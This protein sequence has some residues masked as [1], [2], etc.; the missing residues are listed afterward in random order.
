MLTLDEDCVSVVLPPSAAES[1]EMTR[2]LE[3]LRFPNKRLR[4]DEDD[5][6]CTEE[7]NALLAHARDLRWSKNIFQ[8]M[9]KTCCYLTGAL[10]MLCCLEL[11]ADSAGSWVSGNLRTQRD[12]LTAL[13]FLYVEKKRDSTEQRKLLSAVCARVYLGEYRG[14]GCVKGQLAVGKTLDEPMGGTRVQYRPWLAA[15]GGT[16]TL[17]LDWSA[18][19][20]SPGCRSR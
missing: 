15:D 20:L 1:P 10:L 4:V 12:P 2:P 13:F 18:P 17:R 7:G 16:L 8:E 9:T 5:E 6:T 3:K 11:R 14:N 19:V